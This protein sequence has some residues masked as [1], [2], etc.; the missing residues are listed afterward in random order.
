[1]NKGFMLVSCALLLCIMAEG[2]GFKKLFK[3][4]SNP[5]QTSSGKEVIPPETI[6][7]GLKEALQAGIE[8]GAVKLSSVDGFF[9]DAAIKILMPEEAMK[10]E[11]KLRDIGLGKIADKAILSMNRAAEDASKGA[12]SIFVSAV[13]QMS[14]KDAVGIL[15]GGDF[16]ATNYLKDMT[17]KSLTEAFRPVIEKSFQNVN[18]TKHWETVFTTYNRFSKEKV[19]TDLVAFVTE[20]AIVGIFHQVALEEQKIRKDP[21]AQTTD[22]LKRVFGR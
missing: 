4:A 7:D 22:L 18:A 8:R 14:I 13:K 20:K 3:K 12:V 15:R 5:E 2:Q 17:T 16:A 6:A 11:Q 9:K 19:N 1:M 10:V 21:M